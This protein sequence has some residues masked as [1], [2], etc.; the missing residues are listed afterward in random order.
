MIYHHCTAEP[1]PTS[2]LI[3]A[4]ENQIEAR[5]CMFCSNACMCPSIRKRKQKLKILVRSEKS[6]K[7]VDIKKSFLWSFRIWHEIIEAIILI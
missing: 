6:N 1:V 7:S 5:W 2:K 3:F 4:L